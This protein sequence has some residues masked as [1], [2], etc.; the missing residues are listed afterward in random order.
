MS[1]LSLSSPQPHQHFSPDWA[2]YFL[3]PNQD[4]GAYSP[5]ISKLYTA[6]SVLKSYLY[7]LVDQATRKPDLATIALLLIIILASLKILDILWQTVKFWFRLA[8]RL[9]LW[10]GLAALALW[11][12]NRGPDGM[13]DDLRYWQGQWGKEYVYWKERERVARMMARQGVNYDGGREQPVGS[14]W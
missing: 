9:L 1:A 2:A 6:V 4:Y 12:Y 13:A 3:G 14:W 5:Y 8:R 11:V 7:P 10:G